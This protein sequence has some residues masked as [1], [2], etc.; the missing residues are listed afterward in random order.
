MLL[1]FLRAIQMI[2]RRGSL[3]RLVFFWTAASFQGPRTMPCTRSFAAASARLRLSSLFS[4]S[5]STLFKQARAPRGRQGPVASIL[6][7]LEGALIR[8][9]YPFLSKTS[10]Q[11]LLDHATPEQHQLI[12]HYVV[13]LAIDPKRPDGPKLHSDDD[14]DQ[15]TDDHPIALSCSF[16]LNLARPQEAVD[17]SHP[18]FWR[19]G[20]REPQ[21][22]R[23]AWEAGPLAAPYATQATGV[24]PNSR[25]ASSTAGSFLLLLLLLLPSPRPSPRCKPS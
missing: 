5:R 14:N 10:W 12:S 1:R 8:S 7:L 17:G 15:P 3:I 13:R 2:Y 4:L 6:D 21:R 9:E 11:L 18:V 20:S 16:P 24:G 19:C 23:D 25:R 22:L